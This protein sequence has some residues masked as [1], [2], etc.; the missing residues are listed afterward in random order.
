MDDLQ[1]IPLEE[2]RTYA[3]RVVMDPTPTGW[4]AYCPGL[5]GQGAFAY[6]ETEKEALK[7]LEELLHR[8]GLPEGIQ[9][10]ITI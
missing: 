3:L 5:L 8:P 9:L 6:G 2:T 7:N 1:I 4:L 10:L